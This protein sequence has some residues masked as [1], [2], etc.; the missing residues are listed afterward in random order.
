MSAPEGGRLPL[1]DEGEWSDE[2]REVLGRPPGVKRWK[3]VNALRMLAL[4]PALARGFLAANGHLLGASSLSIRWRELAILRTAAL[5]KCDYEWGQHV[6][7]A[8]E[9]AGLSPA[10][11]ERVLD[12]PD[13]PGWSEVDASILRAADE[14][15]RDAGIGDATW[16]VLARHLDTQQLLD[17]IFTV[18][19]YGTLAM[20]LNSVR[21]PLD[22]GVAGL[23]E[24]WTRE[25]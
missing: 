14:L 18:G 5:S 8:V 24:G 9:Q 3:V 23:P 10:E 19:I 12:G 1:L 11:V 17:L 7:I 6:L 4:H 16:A 13:A 25:E 21:V 2:A 20:A 15:Q 22:P